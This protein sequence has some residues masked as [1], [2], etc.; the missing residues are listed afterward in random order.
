MIESNLFVNI[1][2]CLFFFLGRWTA[3]S[4]LLKVGGWTKMYRL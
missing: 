4:S 2:V 1:I 3:L